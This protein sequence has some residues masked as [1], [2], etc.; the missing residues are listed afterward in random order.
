MSPP[1]TPGVTIGRYVIRTSLGAGGM[2]EVYLADDTQLGR[3]VALKFIH[4]GA[5]R[6]P[7]AE[8]RLLR[9]A[10]A[11]ATLDHPNICA[12]YEV[13][14]ADGRPFIA[15]QYVDGETLEARLRRV[16]LE[17]R[18]ILALAVQIVSAVSDAHAHDILH[19]DLKPANVMVTSRGEAKVM[20]FGLARLG[21]AESGSGASATVSVLSHAGQIVG[22]AAYMSPEQARGEPLDARSD[23]FS[24]GI[25][26]YEMVTGQRPFQGASSAALAAAILTH[27]PL[28]LARFAPQTPA[29][30]ERIV[31]K[32]LK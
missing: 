15:M 30:L 6:D 16:P 1:I 26:L 28:P 32:L 13:G 18:E 24:L 8:R 4:A 29:E 3:K 12:V 19:R 23:L 17:L 2:G 20:D 22:T 21:A 25:V 31:T 10:R 5:E 7:A 9:E 11:A 27:D 14:E